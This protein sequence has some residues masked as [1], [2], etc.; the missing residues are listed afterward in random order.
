M[1][2]VNKIQIIMNG[3][4]AVTQRCP[5]KSNF[6]KILPYSQ[7]NTCA[8]DLQPATLFKRRLWRWCFSVNFAKFL[9]TPVLQKIYEALLLVVT[10][11]RDSLCT[12]MIYEPTVHLKPWLFLSFFCC[13]KY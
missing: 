2:E 6:L 1:L 13:L 5:V 8:T 4:E 7:E 10:A 9:T 3:L 12:N 11:T